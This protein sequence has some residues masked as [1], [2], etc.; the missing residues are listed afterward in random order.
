MLSK[1][2]GPR[3]GQLLRNWVPTRTTEWKRALL[4]KKSNPFGL[5]E[6][7]FICLLALRNCEPLKTSRR[8]RN[9]PFSSR[10]TGR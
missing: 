8:R 1:F 7:S 9:L 4:C 2:M 6:A 5:R 3:Y 10:R